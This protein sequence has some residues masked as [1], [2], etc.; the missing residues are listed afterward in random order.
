[1]D[2]TRYDF[3][4]VGSGT[5][6]LAALA[7][8]EAGLSV[9]IVEKSRYFGGSTALS[10]GGFW[11]PNNTLLRQ[12]GVVDSPDRVREYLRHVTAGETPESRWETHVVH[13]PAAVD[14]LRRRTPLRYQ[15]M[16]DYADY[17]PELPGGSATGRAIEPKPFD[18][19]R[20][21]ADRARLRPPAMAA[22]FPM[23]VSGRTYKW[24][25]LVARKPRGI[26]TGA[27]LLGLGVGGLAIRREYVAGGGALAAGLFA[28][29]RRSG[30]PVWF[31]TPLKELIVEDGRV[32]G[33][34]VTR[35]GADVT[36]RADRG[37]LL[38]AGGFDRRADWRHKYQS[39]QLDTAWSLGNPENTGDA[40]E[41]ATA[42]GADLAFMEESWWF[43]AVPA[44][45]P[46]P[47]PLLAER[48][49][50]G[51][52]IVN[53]QGRRFMN[54]AVNYMTAGQIMIKEELPV[55]MVFDQRYRNRYV[56][57]GGIFPRQALPKA[58]YDAGI[59]HQAPTVAELAARTGLTG[60]P[61]TLDRFNLLAA[62]GRDDDFQ[63]GASAYD[64]YYGDPTITPNPCLGPIDRGPF[65]AVKVVPGDLGTCG[66]IRADGVGRALR[67]DGSVIDGLYATGNS[68][69]NAFGRVYPGPGAT[70]GQGLSFGYAAALHAAGKLP[71]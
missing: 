71:A 38:S 56:F 24:L 13:G 6:M 15:H 16:T 39:E 17:F 67:P 54:E 65:Y 68:A 29:V 37:V 45:G 69:G 46:M 12:A 11:I 51:Q 9:L 34:V 21:G 22:P 48:S 66:G 5:G 40:I 42:A 58:W 19:R 7:A 32:T 63:R 43:P 33:V 2:E 64:R 61:A 3:V 59:A 27:K 18:V 30:I 35:D 1:M 20:L 62:A 50:P 25:N 53:Q 55:W 52:I 10:G 57:G 28:G 14:V 36:V 23:P 47:G 60:L 8:A 26:V 31:E 49:L 44:P 41:I 4:V 70:I